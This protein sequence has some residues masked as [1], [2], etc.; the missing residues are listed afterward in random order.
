MSC[1]SERRRQRGWWLALLLLGLLAVANGG[2]FGYH[3]GARTLYS[4]D[5]QTV[6]VPMIMS[7]SYRRQLGEWLTE[8]I[9][10][11]IE[12]VTPFKVVHSADGADSVLTCRLIADTKRILM[13]NPNDEPRQ[14]E[15]AF[16]VSAEWV[17]RNGD[18]LGQPVN[19]PIP[20]SLNPIDQTA[21]LFPE[22]GQSTTSA[23]MQD[24]KRMSEQI[25]SMME[26][27]W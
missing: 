19:V 14:I 11:R 1:D 12:Q 18:Q 15:M 6:Y 20:P 17:D 7:N 3:M 9:C 16:Q 10:K 27:G 24:V 21:Y 23:Q 2:C 22:L 13:E 8:A 5:V 25:V 26:A 4:P